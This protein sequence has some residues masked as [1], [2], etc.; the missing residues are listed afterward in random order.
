MGIEQQKMTNTKWTISLSRNTLSY[1]STITA[2]YKISNQLSPSTLP[3]LR[4][5]MARK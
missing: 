5:S 3:N 1:A 2:W 4:K